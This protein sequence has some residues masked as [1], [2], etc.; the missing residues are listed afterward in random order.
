M[1][2]K[3]VPGVKV[4]SRKEQ[5]EFP[6]ALSTPSMLP[7]SH[8]SCISASLGICCGIHNFESHSA[9]ILGHRMSTGHWTGLFYISGPGIP[10]GLM[11]V[12]DFSFLI[13]C[14]Y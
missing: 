10:S 3:D 1:N 13:Q 14:Y 4:E 9:I 11:F 2:Y 5:V 7:L 12:L 6:A 8:H